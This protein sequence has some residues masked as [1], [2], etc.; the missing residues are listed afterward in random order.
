MLLLENEQAEALKAFKYKKYD[1]R[2]FVFI[3]KALISGIAEE[4]ESVRLTILMLKYP[5]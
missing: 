5:Q 3:L 2:S 4:T 1:I